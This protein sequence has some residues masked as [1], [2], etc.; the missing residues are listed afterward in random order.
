MAKSLEI[1]KPHKDVLRIEKS[2]T[3]VIFTLVSTLI[4]LCFWYGIL[5]FVHGKSEGII[6]PINIIKTLTKEQ[7]YLWFFILIPLTSLPAI[8]K[9]LKIVIVGEYFIFDARDNQIYKDGNRI[10]KF[11]QIEKVHIRRFSGE[12]ADEYLLSLVPQVG[13]KIKIH[14]SSEEDLLYETADEIADILNVEVERK[15]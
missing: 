15:D 2:K 6:N 1:Q 7:P 13:K 14:K 11:N 3:S 5:L 9:N 8:F 10:S 4:F 12:N